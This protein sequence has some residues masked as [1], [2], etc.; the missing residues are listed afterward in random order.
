MDFVYRPVTEDEW[1][2]WV[3]ALARGFST[4][5]DSDEAE[6]I[7]PLLEFDRSLG[8]FDGDELAGQTL[9]I[10]LGMTVPGGQLPT[11]GVTAVSVLPTHRRQG[12]LTELMRR[13]LEDVRDRG[14]PLAALWA[15]ESVIYG[16]F[17]YGLAAEAHAVRIDGQRT[18][19]AQMPEATGSVRFVP[20]DEALERWPV[21]YDQ[22]RRSRPAMMTRAPGLWS[23]FTV[24]R[25]EKARG[26]FTK[27]QLVEYADASGPAGYAIYAVKPEF[28]EGFPTG[29]L[30]VHE[31]MAASGAAEAALWQYLFG[32]DLIGTIEAVGRPPDESLYWMLA[33]PRRL[34]RRLFDTLWL[35][36][37]DV[38]AAFEGRAYR[39]EGRL[40]LDVQDGFCPWAGG[41]F[42]LSVEGG[43]ATCRPTTLT[44]DITLSAAD[45]A[46]AYLG[47]AR[48]SLLAR[49]GRLEGEPAALRLA[50]ALFGWDVLPWC[51]D[52]F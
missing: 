14:E 43:V 20:R 24:P 41:R 42:E 30:R 32:V 16:R 45:L 23:G 38:T 19:M 29:T 37:L 31:L 48:L 44:A 3:T 25:D 33:D 26:G 22:V 46:A 52:Q 36:I 8:A 50:D 11:A 4:D 15:S 47:G 21:V 34:Q 5:S 6:R 9:A 49:A 18:E 35:R 28:P 17:G 51:A 10:S 7:R 27:R 39:A 1:D 12:A 2:A 13:Q 40:V